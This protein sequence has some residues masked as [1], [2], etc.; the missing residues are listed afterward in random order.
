[1]GGPET[2]ELILLAIGV[3]FLGAFWLGAAVAVVL[4][5]RLVGAALGEWWS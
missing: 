3:L 2:I 1:M 4:I 5:A